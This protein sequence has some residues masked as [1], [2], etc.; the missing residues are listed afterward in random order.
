MM[1]SR[2]RRSYSV[3]RGT[4]ILLQPRSRNFST[5]NEPKNPAPP[6]TIIRLSFNFIIYNTLRSELLIL[7]PYSSLLLGSPPAILNV[8]DVNCVLSQFHASNVTACQMVLLACMCIV[9][10][11]YCAFIENR[12][13]LRKI[14]DH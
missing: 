2:S 7:K 5:T 8:F 4:T 9:E 11:H 1:A 13:Y 6:V 14:V 10:K 3:E 12:N